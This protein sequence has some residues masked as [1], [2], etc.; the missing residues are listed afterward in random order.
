MKK[1]LETL[2]QQHP[3]VSNLQTKHATYKMT[4][5]GCWYC[6]EQGHFTVNCPHREEHLN[7]KKIK[8]LGYTSHI[9]ILQYL[10]ET[11][12]SLVNRL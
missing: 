6:E 10:G 9:I 8:L 5:N 7:Q 2:A 4:S 12:R 1:L 3:G 11:T